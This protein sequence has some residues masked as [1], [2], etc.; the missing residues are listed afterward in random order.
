M[1]LYI[2]VRIEVYSR[3]TDDILWHN[4]ALYSIARSAFSAIAI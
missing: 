2:F 3:Q 1:P 4:R